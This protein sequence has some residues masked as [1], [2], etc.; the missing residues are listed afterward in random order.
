MKLDNYRVLFSLRIL[1]SILLTFVDSFL[2]LYFM[3][4]SDS[5]I[6]PFGIYKLVSITV[7]FFTIFLLQNICKSK[8]RV[9][10]LR[11][12]IILDLIYF[13]TIILLKEQI[14]NYTYILG[15]LYGLEEGFYYSVYNIFESDGVTNEKRKMFNG[16]YKALSS[17]LAIVFPLIF[18]SLI[19]TTGFVKSILIILVIVIIRIIL[20]FIF[21]DSNI[22]IAE[23]TD[24]KEYWLK[25]RN[26]KSIKSVY[27]INLF[28]GLT[29]SDGAFKSIITIYI[30]KVFSDSF[31]LGIFTSIFSLISC[32]LGLLFVKIIKDKNYVSTISISMVL[33]IFSLC[34]MILKCNTYTIVI[35][36]LFQTI[37]KGLVELINGNSQANLSNIDLIRNEY[38]VEYFLGIEISLFIGRFISQSLFILMAFIDDIYLIPVFII[39]LILLMTNSLKLQRTERKISYEYRN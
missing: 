20:S 3:N 26:N 35:F 4:I 31:S 14:V 38:K 28:N 16:H 37:S 24:M 32:L 36:N 2:V 8:N 21:K 19:A 11:I 1:K 27:M 25:A 9:N 33:T 15:I 6:L 5:N 17:I 30:I 29:Y 39:F 10:L 22:P 18:G 34:L 23:K 12:G 7:V 13:L